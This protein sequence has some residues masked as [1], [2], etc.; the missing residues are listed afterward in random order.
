VLRRRGEE[1]DGNQ[2]TP[3]ELVHAGITEK[4][5]RSKDNIGNSVFIDRGRRG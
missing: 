4:S 3:E 1:S 2:G 5:R